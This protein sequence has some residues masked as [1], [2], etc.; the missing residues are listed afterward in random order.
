MPK[1]AKRKKR[2]KHPEPDP[3]GVTVYYACENADR[4]H[5]MGFTGAHDNL[6]QSHV[7][8]KHMDVKAQAKTRGLLSV[9]VLDVREGGTLNSID[10][11]EE[12][13]PIPEMKPNKKRKPPTIV[14]PRKR[15][16]L[17]KHLCH[18][19]ERNHKLHMVEIP[20]KT[21]RHG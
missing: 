8:P 14:N 7:G 9:L 2:K 6:W 21:L 19:N 1:P 15:K 18:R 11:D 5:G 3:S 13:E 17:K 16:R 20:L 10:S 12:E 4:T